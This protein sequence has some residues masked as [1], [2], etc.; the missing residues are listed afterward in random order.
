MEGS[1]SYDNSVINIFQSDNVTFRIGDRIVCV[2]VMSYH[3]INGVTDMYLDYGAVK[4]QLNSP[5]SS[6]PDS[7]FAEVV[8]LNELEYLDYLYGRN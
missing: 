6:I 7:M 3:S 5:Y 1:R 4:Y 2:Y 8:K